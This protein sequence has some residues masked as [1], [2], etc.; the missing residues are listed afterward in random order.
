MRGW[1]NLQGAV[2]M[3]D[4]AMN[5]LKK[6]MEEVMENNESHQ[7]HKAEMLAEALVGMIEVFHEFDVPICSVPRLIA[8]GTVR[9]TQK[10]VEE[11]KKNNDTSIET[12][13]KV[14][15]FTILQVELMGKI[16]PM[17]DKVFEDET[18]E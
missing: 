14:M 8:L 11:A 16:C 5:A 1:N 3:K 12:M 10:L 9:F 13:N 18:E 4:A 6:A 17:F 15:R 7:D 2:I